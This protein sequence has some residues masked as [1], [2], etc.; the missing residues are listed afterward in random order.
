MKKLVLA[1]VLTAFVVPTFTFAQEAPKAEK[2][3]KKKAPKK[4]S[5]KKAEAPKAQ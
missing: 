3:K 2:T 4:S 5:K 1:L